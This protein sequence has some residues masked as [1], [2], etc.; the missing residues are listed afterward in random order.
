MIDHILLIFTL[1]GQVTVAA[2][3]ASLEDCERMKAAIS[4]TIE[5]HNQDIK[6][7][8]GARP[9]NIMM[10]CTAIPEREHAK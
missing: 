5:V 7:I 6:V 1:A 9:V 8:R 3:T 2:F 4:A 10:A